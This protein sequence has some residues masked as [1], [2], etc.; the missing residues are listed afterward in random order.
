METNKN[1]P[2]QKD[3]EEN[4]CDQQIRDEIKKQIDLLND[5]ETYKKFQL[6]KKNINPNAGINI[7]DEV[8]T[9]NY[10]KL[11]L[12]N[13]EWLRYYYVLCRIKNFTIAAKFLNITQQALSKAISGIESHIGIKLIER[14]RNLNEPT[15]K[16]TV[17]LEKISEVIENLIEINDSF[18]NLSLNNKYNRSIR[19]GWFSVTGEKLFARSIDKFLSQ[20]PWIYF[21]VNFVYPDELL[22]SLSEKKLDIGI[23][24]EKITDKNFTCIGELKQKYVIAGKPQKKKKWD[25]F[26]YICPTTITWDKVPAIH[27]EIWPE[28]GF[29][30]KVAMESSSIILSIEMCKRGVGVCAFNELSIREELNRGELAIVADIPFK[31]ESSFYFIVN[32]D[33]IDNYFLSYFIEQLKEEISFSNKVREQNGNFG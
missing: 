13:S 20:Y 5:D 22:K 4:P 29:D 14:Y 21:D 19:L 23:S 11:L 27:T 9:G 18:N 1:Q 25:E 8:Y 24:P 6:I 33:Y 16:G 32:N 30:R 28:S 15:L 31:H 26:Y 17:F 2:I 7:K 3:S 10:E 12:M